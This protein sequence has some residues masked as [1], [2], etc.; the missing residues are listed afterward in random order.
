M[1]SAIYGTNG[2]TFRLRPSDVTAH[3]DWQ[4]DVNTRL[5]AGGNTGSN[6]FIE[7]GFNGNGN[8][9][10]TQTIGATGTC[11]VPVNFVR[12]ET[13]TPLEF[14]KIVGTGTDMWPPNSTYDW[15]L[16][17]MKVS[18]LMPVVYFSGW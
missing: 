8:F 18:F 17:C 7:F 6:Y 1:P 12:D 11:G 13:V 10:Y 4:K 15:T 3:L 2:G 16:S 14:Q 9:L 5:V